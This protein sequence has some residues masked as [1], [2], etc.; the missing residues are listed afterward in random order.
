MPVREWTE[1]DRE[2][3]AQGGAVRTMGKLVG[4]K[5]TTNKRPQR[6]ALATVGNKDRWANRGKHIR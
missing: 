3:E 6:T 5:R 2:A 1:M 4:V